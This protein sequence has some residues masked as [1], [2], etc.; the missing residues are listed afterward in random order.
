MFKL[1]AVHVFPSLCRINSHTSCPGRLL[2]LKR[3]P[4]LFLLVGGTRLNLVGTGSNDETI[5]TTPIELTTSRCRDKCHLD[6]RRAALGT[7]QHSIIFSAR[8]LCI[9]VNPWQKQTNT[10]LHSTSVQAWGM[11]S[12][13][14]H[15]VRNTQISTSNVARILSME[16]NSGQLLRGLKKHG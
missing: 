5:S 3:T 13:H 12:A 9:P 14:A 6:L 7:T 4:F 8:L 10:A 2:P 11:L 16:L 1:L 15:I